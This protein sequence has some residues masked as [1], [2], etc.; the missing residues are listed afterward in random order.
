MK[1]IQRDIAN[2]QGF[3]VSLFGKKPTKNGQSGDGS[4]CW[5]GYGKMI[6]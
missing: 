2:G 3:A 4:L 1:A 6:E 5:Q